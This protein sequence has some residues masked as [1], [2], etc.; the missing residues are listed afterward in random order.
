MKT[1]RFSPKKVTVEGF[2]RVKETE[3]VSNE[4][5]KMIFF[6]QGARTLISSD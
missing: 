2:L 3:F 1:A 6:I 4:E 5:K